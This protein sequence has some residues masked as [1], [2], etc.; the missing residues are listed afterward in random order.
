MK[1]IYILICFFVFAIYINAQSSAFKGGVTVKCN[2]LEERNDSLKM[3][4]SVH[5]MATALNTTQSWTIVPHMSFAEELMV[6]AFPYI[7]I[8]GKN[9]SQMY[10]RRGM[11]GQ[12]ALYGRPFMMVNVEEDTDTV[13]NYRIQ[14]PY[15]MWMDRAELVLYQELRSC[16]GD[17]QFFTSELGKKVKLI[18][19]P[20]YEVQTKS[21]YFA[22]APEQKKR[23]LQGQAFLDFPAGRSEIIPDFRRNPEE[24]AKINAVIGNVK[25]DNDVRITGIYVEGYASPEGSWKGNERLS[26]ERSVALKEYIEK[27]FSFSPELFS[28]KSVAE[29][30]NGLATLIE[31]S[32]LTNREQALRIA[33]SSADYDVREQQL[34]AM[35]ATYRRLLMEFFPQLRRVEY[36]VDFTVRDYTNEQVKDLVTRKPE[37]LSHLELYKLACSYSEGSKERDE[38]FDMMGRLFPDDPTA[39]VNLASVMLKRGESNTARRYLEKATNDPRTYNAWGVLYLREGKLE[40]A[41]NYFNKALEQGVEEA[42]HNLQE[43][44]KKR[45]D[46]QRM[47]RY[48]NR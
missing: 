47:K 37:Q 15:E 7:L 21:V 24:L 32:S 9:K 44:K 10:R 6:R 48:E 8:N 39:N 40:V 27:K 38:L 16:A 31:A 19:R 25:N 3:E 20:A 41:E 46:M 4:L 35:S 13:F 43:V 45:E 11:G 23:K 36:Q 1:K 42:A 17:R 29:D 28:V 30:W 5:V 14:V 33:R 2:L 12:D 26:K 22:P 34:K 18:P